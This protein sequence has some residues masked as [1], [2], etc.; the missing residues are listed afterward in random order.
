VLTAWEIDPAPTVGVG[1]TALL[2]LLALQR[3]RSSQPGYSWRPRAGRPRAHPAAFGV[4]LLVLLVAIDGPPDYLS[5][6]SFSAH[7]V[8]HLLIQL[9]AA[10]LLIL[11]APLSLLL[12]A[13]TRWLPRR[14]L[15]G[16]LRG[17]AVGVVSHP[18]AAFALFAAVMVGSHLTPVYNLA[19]EHQWV[20]Q[21][22]HLGYLLTALLFWWPAIGIDPGPHRLA[23]PGRVLY[24]LLIMPV[25]AFL[26]VAIV[27]T[28]RVLYPYY[29]VHPPP[30]GATP[31]SDQGLA[32]ILMWISGMLIITPAAGVALLRWLDQDALDQARREATHLPVGRQ[33]AGAAVRSAHISFED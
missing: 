17:R 13:D 29:A 18:V 21:V 32:G 20:H 12:R 15:A 33:V 10:P 19:L 8:Q 31:L 30:W 27:S 3:I 14:R 11:G 5:E 28:G 2:Y 1:A 7:M 4:G 25:M 6:S 24:L 22:E 16:V 26:G 23:H 9:V